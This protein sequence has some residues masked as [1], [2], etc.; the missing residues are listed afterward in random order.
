LGKTVGVNQINYN[1]IFN[2]K[3]TGTVSR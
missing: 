1:A 2:C 3:G